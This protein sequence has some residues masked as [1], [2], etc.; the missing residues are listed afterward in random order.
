M[1][2]GLLQRRRG[3]RMLARDTARIQAA[4]HSHGSL[5]CGLPIRRA[6][7]PT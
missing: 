6:I 2:E 3:V 1:G 4:I 7:V 5:S